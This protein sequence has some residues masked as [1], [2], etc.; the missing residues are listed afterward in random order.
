MRK[1]VI[2]DVDGVIVFS[3]KAYQQR[4]AH[5]FEKIGLPVSKKTQEQ[6][7]GSNAQDMFEYL[8]PNDEKSVRN[9]YKLIKHFEGNIR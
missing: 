3:E 6:F 1:A 7:V 2:F 8:V 5:F 9:Y 4:R